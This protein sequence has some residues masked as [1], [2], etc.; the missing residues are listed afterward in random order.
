[1]SNP[2]QS[3]GVNKNTET[4]LFLGAAALALG[5]AVQSGDGHLTPTALVW[6]TIAL[7]CSGASVV[8]QRRSFPPI[9]TKELRFV[10]T[11]GLIWQ[12]FQLITTLPGIYMLPE[13]LSRIWVFK[14]GIAIA[15]SSAL[16]SLAPDTWLSQRVKTGLAGLAISAIFCSGM[17]VI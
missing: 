16:L 7:I 6:L 12:I 1:M 3:K 11:I 14:T 10:L 9:S 8:S 2:I 17:W 4:K 13:A 15:G 5:Q